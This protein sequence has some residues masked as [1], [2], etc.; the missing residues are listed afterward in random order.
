MLACNV[1]FLLEDNAI[2]SSLLVWVPASDTT[3]CSLDHSLVNLH[4]SVKNGM[5][6]NAHQSVKDSTHI[7]RSDT[8][9]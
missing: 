7:A 4:R 6:V 2:E 9:S 1:R 5:L 3:D 8:L